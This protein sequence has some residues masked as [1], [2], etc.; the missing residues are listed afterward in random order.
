MTTK[1]CACCKEVKPFADFAAHRTNGLQAYCRPCSL[2][3]SREWAA[4]NRERKNA[5]KAASRHS[6]I[7]RDRANR[8]RHYAN[9]AES[10]RKQAREAGPDKKAKRAARQRRYR[11]ENPEKIR[12]LNRAR[13][14]TKRAAGNVTRADIERLIALQKG[15]CA[16]CKKVTVRHGKG[17][18]LDHKTPLSR[19]GTNYFGNLQILCPACNLSKSDRDPHEFMVERGFLL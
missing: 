12:Q 11:T 19:G 13:V 15:R 18:H 1:L 17:F 4:K 2:V 6:D 5:H 3:K 16:A 7:E 10:L 8:R 9:N 14:A